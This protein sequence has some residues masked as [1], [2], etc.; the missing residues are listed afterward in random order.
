MVSQIPANLE[1]LWF[2]NSLTG[3]PLGAEGRKECSP[4]CKEMIV[5]GEI[6]SGATKPNRTRWEAVQSSC[7]AGSELTVQR[8]VNCECGLLFWKLR[9][10]EARPGDSGALRRG[11]V[12]ERK[13]LLTSFLFGILSPRPPGA[14]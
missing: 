14:S 11:L 5:I 4:T 7:R 1:L 9:G 13:V 6:Q 3:C 8:R 12:K 10:G 2:M